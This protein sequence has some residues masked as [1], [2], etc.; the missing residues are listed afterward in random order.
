ME[1][2]MTD[3]ADTQIR[4]FRISCSEAEVDDMHERIDHTRWPEEVPGTG[5]EHG[6]PTSYVRET[7][8]H[9][10]A[11]TNVVQWSEFDRGGHFAA[12]ETPDLL[13]DD[14]RTFFRRVR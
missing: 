14:L 11:N 2:A 9:E 3:I 13:I 8:D 7:A 1:S 4:P 6:M 12:I 5:W 10:R